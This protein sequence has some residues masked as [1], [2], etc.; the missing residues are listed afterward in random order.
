MAIE[1]KY[2]P[3]EF[4]QKVK[5]Y[6]VKMETSVEDF[7]D[8]DG[9][10]NFLDIDDEEYETMKEKDSPYFKTYRWA[11]RRRS[12]WLQRMAPKAK[13]TNGIKVLMSQPQNGG[14][15]D[16]P[17][18]KTPRQMTVILR[19]LDSNDDD[20][21]SLDSDDDCDDGDIGRD[22]S[23]NQK[24]TGRK[25]SRNRKPRSTAGESKK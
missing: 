5:A 11:R 2:T 25:N 13:N 22:D 24:A 4:D 15:V 16:K 1:Y 10:L 3:E 8:E 9:L 20:D 18:D 6:H 7:P 23:E 19:G 17:V 21:V 12:S 14:I